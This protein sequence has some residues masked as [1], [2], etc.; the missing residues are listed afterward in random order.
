[1]DAARYIR[2]YDRSGPI[3]A[4]SLLTRIYGFD[5]PGEA[6]LRVIEMRVA[7][8]AAAEQAWLAVLEAV[9]EMQRPPAQ[10]QSIH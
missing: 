7:G 1:L 3:A 10:Q 5:A 9:T 6:L 2:D 8:N 4:A